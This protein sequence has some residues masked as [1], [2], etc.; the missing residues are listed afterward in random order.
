[1]S[2]SCLFVGGLRALLGRNECVLLLSGSIVA[3]ASAQ[4]AVRAHCFSLLT[5]TKSLDLEAVTRFPCSLLAFAVVCF[6][7][8]S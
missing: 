3:G 2:F 4:Y 8:A 1:M 6:A 7:F 5:N